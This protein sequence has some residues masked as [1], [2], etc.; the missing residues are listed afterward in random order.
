MPKNCMVYWPLTINC[1][2]NNSQTHGPILVRQIDDSR[3]SQMVFFPFHVTYVFPT[4]LPSTRL[5]YR[6]VRVGN[7][8]SE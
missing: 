2:V 8:P 3:C 5:F 4:D 6:C 1:T 7:I